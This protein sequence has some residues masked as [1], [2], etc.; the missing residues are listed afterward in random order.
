MCGTKMKNTKKI[1]M[2]K[3]AFLLTLDAFLA[4]SILIAGIILL[5]QYSVKEPA[6]ESIQY[7]TTDILN[8]LSE[9]E[10]NELEASKLS[11]YKSSSIYTNENL[12]IIEQV[13]T[14]WA[15]NQT[16]LAR[17]LTQL[18]VENLLD[19]NTGMELVMGSE[20]LYL[21]NSP[22]QTDVFASERMITG[23]LQGAPLTGST[24]SAYLRKISDKR[25]TSYAYFGGFVGQGNITIRLENLPTDISN[26]TITEFT[27]EGEFDGNFTVYVNGASC[28][29]FTPNPSIITTLNISSCNNKVKSGNNSASLIF[30]SNVYN[31]SVSGGLIRIK[32][33]TSQLADTISTGIQT[34]YFPEIDGVINLYDGL[35]VPGTMLNMTLYLHYW[36]SNKSSLPLFLEIGNTTVLSLNA[37]NTQSLSFNNTYLSSLLNY[38]SLS[39]TTVPIR[40]GFYQGD[41]VNSSGNVTNIFIITSR[42]N[43]MGTNDIVVNATTNTTRIIQ[44]KQVDNTTVAIILNNTGNNIGL[45]SFGTGA[46]VD[47]DSTLT[48]NSAQLY[49]AINAYA[50]HSADAQR[51]LCGAMETAKAQLNASGGSKTKAII[52][53]TDGD[54]LKSSGQTP[55]CAFGNTNTKAVVWQDVVNEACNTSDTV[56]GNPYNITFYTVAF[57]PNATNDPAIVAN[58]S[59]IANCTG[60]MFGAGNN[61]SAIATI[62]TQFAEA[63]KGSKTV[64]A[65]QRVTAAT[66]VNSKLYNDSYIQI[67][68]TP[69]SSALVQNQLSATFETAQFKSCT[70]TV[71]IPTGLTVLQAQLAS[72]SGDYWTKTVTVDGN[73]VYNLSKYAQNYTGL[74]DPYRILIPS[75]YLTSGN[76]TIAF[77]I[78][79]DSSTNA[80]CS[81]NNTLIYTAL[82]QSATT[83]S[84]VVE[85]ADGCEWTIEYEDNTTEV[86]LIPST[87][88]GAKKCKYISSNYTLSQG[89]YDS[90]DAYDISAYNLLKTLDFDN[91]GKLFFKLNNED[92]E[93][94]ITTISSVPYLWGPSTI[95]AKVWQ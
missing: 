27:L 21:K 10:M 90:S 54:L 61:A 36:V 19:D 76:H 6:R 86:K 5:S 45:V 87:Y 72:Y 82:V 71:N 84:D 73:V 67:G 24:S 83:R 11:L 69:T 32:Y 63:L 80:G 44:A 57:G 59:K 34:Q 2:G 18:F 58:L 15:A 66:N 51:Y 65:F 79:P 53:M 95:I 48:N 74:G 4:A 41:D 13:A 88:S 85:T 30:T 17:N 68:Y 62:Y 55:T 23:V 8:A 1:K 43:S 9:I 91:N 92:V 3:K 50:P 46:S 38:A 14:Y 52:L 42:H 56:H 37:T 33:K 47:L 39:N 20:S 22:G 29:N 7:A 49:A 78:G 89:A 12:T 26:S 16:D 70:N 60:G 25:T 81:L 64:Y 40:L 35:I 75:N 77:S 31:A 28:A 94:S 93:I